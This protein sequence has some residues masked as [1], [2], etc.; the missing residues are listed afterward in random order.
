MCSSDL[1][2]A[3]VAGIAG[4]KRELSA[5]DGV[6]RVGVSAGH[7]GEFVFAV[8]HATTLDLA[9]V[10]PGLTAFAATVTGRR[11]GALVV[12]AAEPSAAD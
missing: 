2:L 7:T 5:I 11:E 8:S 6:R 3:S 1:G 9:A 12:A 10:I 4:F